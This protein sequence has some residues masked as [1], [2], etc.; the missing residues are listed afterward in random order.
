MD[1]F[2]DCW[3][4]LPVFE[5]QER[6]ADSA[7]LARRRGGVAAGT[8]LAPM[9]AS[10]RGFGTGVQPDL[11]SRLGAV[12]ADTLLLTGE[13]DAKF[14]SS[15]DPNG[16]LYAAGKPPGRSWSRTT[17]YTW[18]PLICGV[19]R[20][21]AFLAPGRGPGGHVSFA[22]LSCSFVSLLAPELLVMRNVRIY[23]R[24]LNVGRFNA[25]PFN[26]ALVEAM[27]LKAA[28]LEATPFHATPPPVTVLD[29]SR[30]VQLSRSC[31][32]PVSKRR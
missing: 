14:S 24:V 15:C 11:C 31:P 12:E 30:C 19:P 26:V 4:A 5:G 10:L 7:R 25:G 6:R 16:R 3:R 1:G 22:A 2:L 17:A 8:I 13:L 29:P 9:A 28:L 32:V 23:V 18:M 20:S 27:P 21:E